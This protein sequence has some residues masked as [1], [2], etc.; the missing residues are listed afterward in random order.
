M[1]GD[2][3]M[4]IPNPTHYAPPCRK[5]L[6]ENLWL[7]QLFAA[8]AVQKG[9]IIRRKIADVDRQ[10]GRDTLLAEVERRGFH[11]ILCGRQFVII[12]NSGRLQVLT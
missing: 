11:A 2:M 9:G 1:T 4:N 5:T 3:Q 7:R 6:P 8:K 10:I 12:C